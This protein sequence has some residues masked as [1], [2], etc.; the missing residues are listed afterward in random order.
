MSRPICI[1]ACSMVLTLASTVSAQ[2]PGAPRARAERAAPPRGGPPGVGMN[3]GRPGRDVAEELLAHTGELK[4]TDQQ[5]TRL[6]AIARRS[7]DRRESLRRAM[8]STLMARRGV[9]PDSMRVGPTPEL[10]ATM[11]RTRDQVHAELRDAL[12]VL[13]PDQL[14]TAWEI[15]ADRRGGPGWGFGPMMG[16][17]GGGPAIRGGGPRGFGRRGPGPFAPGA[18]PDRPSR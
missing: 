18:G 5:V 8:D 10:R 2:A 11:E 17:V 4:L 6:A 13:T 14:A 1:L 3:A 12:G 9:R 15:V 7:A 16:G